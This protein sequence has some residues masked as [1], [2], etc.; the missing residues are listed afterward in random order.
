MSENLNLRGTNSPFTGIYQDINKGAVLTHTELD[1][2]F[3][4]LKGHIVYDA[5]VDVN[6]ITL[7]KLNGQDLTIDLVIPD[8]VTS[9]TGLTFNPSNYDLIMGKS[10][11]TSYTQS[12]SILATDM[13]VTGGT[14]NTNTGIVTF[15]NNSGGTFTVSGFLTGMT[16]T[17]WTSGST[18]NYSIK[19]K[20]NSGL[21]ATGNYALAEGYG[22]VGSGNYSHAEGSNSISSGTASHSEGGFTTASGNYSHAEGQG[23]K[24]SGLISHA[25]GGGTTSSGG[26][27][28]HSEGFLTK[29][30]GKSSHTEGYGT[31]ASGDYGSH[32][33]GKYTTASG[34]YGSHSEGFNTT[35]S[36][37]Y[38][39]A[40]GS[41]TLSSGSNSHAEGATT[42]ASGSA[43][44]AEGQG[45]TAS[46]EVSHVE[47]IYTIASG[48]GSHAEGSSTTA[49]GESSHA[50]GNG[51]IASGDASHAEGNQT[52]ASG[53]NS[54]ASGYYSIAS[55]ATSHAEGYQT[56]A[57][58]NYGSHAEGW[59]TKA[60]GWVSHAEGQ[61]TTASGYAA[62]SEGRET[63]ASGYY[64]HAEGMTNISSGIASHAEGRETTA[65][66]DASHTE[67]DGTT[68]IGNQSHAEGFYST[69]SGDYS[70]VEGYYSLA[71][72]DGSHAE[73]GW[74]DVGEILSGGTALGKASHAEGQETI[75]GWKG[76]TIDSVVDGLI[77]LNSSYGDVT[78]EFT[79][80]QVILNNKYYFYNTVTFSSTTNTQILLDDT[81]VNGGYMYV[82]DID[83]LNSQYADN[84]IGNSSHT[85]GRL[86][87]ALGDQAHAEGN[88]TT[89][90]GYAAH[91]EGSGTRAI[92]IISHAEGQG[93]TAIGSHSH[94]E[95]NY[96]IALGY[97][98]HVEGEYT[99]ASGSTSHAE[100]Q[101]TTAIGN[102]SHAEGYQTTAIGMVSHTEGR[103]TT[104]SGDYSHAEGYY[105]IASGEGS[106]AEGGWNDN[107]EILS[108]GTALGKA[109]HAEG[110]ET[111][112]G[113]KGFSVDSTVSGV[114]TLNSSYGDVTSEFTG[115][116]V[117]LDNEIYNFSTVTFS[118][119]TN[120]EIIL[121]DITVNGGTYV[122]DLD[123][124]NSQYADTLDVFGRSAHAEGNNTKSL[125]VDS[126]SEGWNTIATGAYGS[127]AEGGLTTASAWSSHAEGERTTASGT[128]SHAE[129]ELT[130]AIGSRSHSEGYLTVAQGNNSHAEGQ[131]TRS[132]SNASHAEGANTTA[133]GQN[134]HA[135][136]QYTNAIGTNSSASG[137]YTT[138]GWKGFSVD[139]VVNGLIM[140]T[141]SYGDVT[142]EFF[143]NTVILDNN[144]YTYNT[145]TFSSGT[146]T[147][148]ILN[149]TS[150]NFGYF[151]SDFQNINSQYANNNKG[152]S[153][154]TEGYI[155]T[156]LGNYSHAEGQSTIASGGASHAEGAGTTAIGAASHSEGM[157]TTA[158]GGQSHAE[159]R[160]TTA[161]GSY[162][163]SEGFITTAIGNYSHAEGEYT[164]AI[165]GHS[166][167]E[168]W[169]TI[170]SGD[171]SHAEGKETTASGNYSHAEGQWTAAIGS[172]SHAEGYLTTAS[173]VY[174]AHAE[175]NSSKAIGNWS[176]AE[177]GSTTASGT[178]SHA[179]GS[180]TIALGNYSHAEGS[181][182]TASGQVSHA[183]GLST[184][185]SGNQSHAEGTST[186]ASGYSSH[187][188]GY[189]T[190]A[191]GQRSHAEGWL[192]T[193][194]SLSSHAE[195]G[196]TLASGYASHAEGS[197]TTASGGSSHAEGSSTIAS[198]NNSHTEGTS[199]T[200]SGFASHAGGWNTI[201][202]GDTSFI[203][204]NNSA[205]LGNRS[206]VLGG[207][208]IT[209]STDD[210]V[211]VPYF[212][213]QSAT[214]DNELVEVLVIDTNGD[215]K[216]RDVSSIS[217]DIYWTSGSTGNYSIKAKN[218]SGLDATGNYAVA[219]GNSTMAS[220]DYGSHAEG[221]STMASGNYGSH[222]EGGSTTASGNYGSHAEGW[223]TTAS[224]SY[225]SHAEGEGTIA[226]GQRSHAEGWLTTASSLSSHAEG[227]GTIAS[228]QRS[229]AE[230]WL[231]TASSLSSH[232]E[233]QQTIASGENSHAEG[234]QTTAI[235]N[236]SHA[237][238]DRNVASG[239]QSHAEGQFTVASGVSSHAEGSNTISEGSYSHAEGDH[240]TAVGNWSH[241]EGNHTTTYGD[242][243]HAEGN[244][245]IATGE[246][247][248]AEG[249][250]TV[251][252]WKGFSIDSVVDGL[253]TLN[254]SYGNVTSE[255]I[256]NN[257][258]ILDDKIYG[259]DTIT[260]SSTTNTQILLDDITVNSG[261]YI[262]DID[263]LNSQYADNYLGNSTHAE[264]VGTKALG[265]NSHAE[266]IYSIALGSNSHAEGYGAFASGF[267]SHAEGAFTVASG[268]AAH[269][270][271]GGTIAS[272]D[273]SH[274]EGEGTTA[275]GNYSHAEGGY[276]T[277]SGNFSHA[278]GDHTTASGSYG[279]HA[280]GYQTTA[281]SL[282]SHSEGSATVA[283]G[284]YSHSEGQYTTAS[285]Y[286]SHAEGNASISNG[287]ASHS[288]GYYTTA[289]GNYSHSE[290]YYTTASG[291]YSH[292]EGQE[293][294]AGW[295]GFT[296]DS[297]V[298]GLITLNSSYGDVTGE[299]TGSAVILDTKIYYYTT[300]TF[301]STTNTQIL[302]SDITAIG[303]NYV[304]DL[305]NLNSQYA[306]NYVGNSAHAEG[307]G[308]Y[309]LGDRA[310]AEGFYT[311][312]TGVNSHTEGGSTIAIG[313]NSHA[314]GD[315]TKAIGYSSH[316]EGYY[317]LAQGDGSHA[318]GYLVI[319]SGLRAHA[320]GSGSIAIGD[321]SHAEGS[322]TTASGN[323]SHAEGSYTTA[324]GQGSH[325][326]GE[327]TVASEYYSHAE[328]L[329][330]IASGYASHAEGGT[331]TANGGYS[332]AE[333]YLTT[334]IGDFSHAEGGYNI[335]GG[336]SSH[337]GGNNS[338]ASGDTSFIHSKYSLVTGDRS[339]VLG[340]QFI[341]GSTDD[342]VYVP[343][344]NIQSATTNNNLTD[345]LVLDTN[346]DVKKRTINTIDTYATGFT[347]N[348]SN[349][350]LI[351]NQNNGQSDLSVNLGLLSSDMTVTGGTYNSTTGIATFTNNTGGTFTVLGFLTGMTDT[352][353]SGFTYGNNTL[354]IKQ[355]AGK[356]DLS[357]NIDTLTGLTINGN[358][359]ATTISNVDYIDF[360]KT[361]VVS[362]QEGR[363]HWN[364]S[365]KT[366][367]IDTENSQVQLK[368]GHDLV[369]R[370]NNQTASTILKGSAVYIN[371]EQGQR[372]TITLANYSGESTSAGTLGL[373]MGNISPSSNGY[374]I[375][376]GILEG[377]NTLAYSAGTPLYL[378][379]GGT[380]TSTKP[381]APNHDVRIG[382]VIV[383]NAT[384]G[385]IYV[386]IQNGYE[387]DELHD[388][389]ITSATTG[390][391]LV[392][393]TY[394]G[395][396]VW[397]N[398]KTLTGDYVVNGNLNVTGGTQSIFSG[399]SSSDLVR[400]TQTG[401]GNAFV[402]EDGNNPDATPFIIDAN[403]DVAI[404][405][406]IPGGT[407][408]KLTVQTSATS[409][410]IKLGGGN[411]L[412]NARLYLQSDATNAYMDMYGNDGYLPFRI[413]AAP[414]LLN[415]T[416]GTG[417]VGI[418]TFSPTA[419]LH[420]N[421]TYKLGIEGGVLFS[422]HGS[423][424]N[425][426]MTTLTG[427]GWTGSHRVS[428]SDSNGTVFFGAYGSST[429]LISSHWTVGSS[430]SIDGY[431][432]TTGI[433]LLKNGNVGIGTATPTQKLSVS[434][435]SVT[436]DNYYI[437]GAEYAQVPYRYVKQVSGLVSGTW[438]NICNV[439]GDS[440]SSGI[441][442]SI[443]GTA[444]ATVIDVVADIL[445]N[446]SQDIFI[447]SKSG[448]Y[449]I[450]T[451]RV[452]SDD[453]QNFTIQATTNSTSSLTANVE[454][455]PLNSESVI[456]DSITPYSGMLLQHDCVP[457]LSISSTDGISSNISNITTKGYLGVGINTPT[458]SLH[459]NNTG[460][461]NSFLVEDDS[462]PDN[463]P[464]IIDNQGRV[465]LGTNTPTAKLHV[466]KGLQSDTISVENSAA[467]IAGLDVGLAI[468]QSASAPYGNW[469]QSLRPSD[470][471]TF[472][473]LLNPSGSNVGIGITIPT[474]SLHV[475][476]TAVPSAGETIAQFDVSDDSSYLRI[477][478]STGAN[479]TFIPA[480]ESY[481]SSNK[482]A[483][484]T[485]GNGATDTGA[486]PLL[487]FDARIGAA[488]VATRPL[489]QWS[490]YGDVKMTMSASGNIG[491][492]TAS[493]SAKLHVSGDTRITGTLT[494]TTISAT[495]Y[496]N[497]PLDIYTTGGTYNSGT[498]IATFTNNS[499]GTFIVSGFTTGSTYQTLEEVLVN[500]N[501]TGQNWI[502]VD[503][504][505]SGANGIRNNDP[506]DK[507]KKIEFSS[508]GILTEV[509]GNITDN[510][511][512]ISIVQNNITL[513]S[514]SDT[515]VFPTNEAFIELHQNGNVVINNSNSLDITSEYITIAGQSGTFTGVEYDQD[516]STNFTN[517][518][519]VDKEYVDNLV[520]GGG[521]FTGGTV[522]G[523]TNFTGGLSAN[524]I[525]ATTYQNLPKVGFS[526][527][528][529]GVCDTAPTA[530]STQYYY[531]TIGEVT[532][533]LS[534]VKLWGFSGSDLVL[535]GIY[536]GTL[537]GTMTLIGQASGTC[538]TGPNELTLTAETGQNLTITAGEDLVV[539]YYPDGTNWRTVYDLGISD[540][541]FG[542][543]NTT[544]ITTMPASPTGTATAIRFACTLY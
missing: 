179:E 346:G 34:D 349:Y 412:G 292:S 471:A 310:H 377:V 418:G 424:T 458:A 226:S 482:T 36:G 83:N 147:E 105:T 416:V 491:I 481:N 60:S 161:S 359:T 441:K 516:Y 255:F 337:A 514:K 354:T 398:S 202:S 448:V 109:S 91:S 479:N 263:K 160:N 342:T 183:E 21:N 72:G 318:E 61:W 432:L 38:S 384:T 340:G 284:N 264:G 267:A 64:S 464:F 39:H 262:A 360:N 17:Y 205:V 104:A 469:I 505:G 341:T 182:T 290:G 82:A 336:A 447:E 438:T 400:I 440:L 203:H 135:E 30:I 174:G 490:N 167:A 162:S 343:Y 107:G 16:D 332:H 121:I 253:I 69:A 296:V 403:G 110:Q 331:T 362:H 363:I 20:N 304:A 124:L 504:S 88:S 520:V 97:S 189:G 421:G 525:S 305:N 164:T 131:G 372:P 357:V 308:T 422:S 396:N 404:G 533:T 333:G 47:G 443:M 22:T 361:A 7:K 275:S 150:I 169:D 373:A 187:A 24:A 215:V 74:N 329:G 306:D 397:V 366:L 143:S 486:E 512:S 335:A 300:V 355:T 242:K 116:K 55:G 285:G 250:E 117:I 45:S 417:N 375:T 429:S 364:D 309:A 489:F 103:G 257:T 466:V 488:Q 76:F 431:D 185:A 122:A 177:G 494:A 132:L 201:A 236:N 108:G 313:Q 237:E 402:V 228:G 266:G 148:I 529:V 358:L 89:A 442:L 497:L 483:L 175:G 381:Q 134:S 194:S 10:D 450:L 423:G 453:N 325:A 515:G 28:S 524:T 420:V 112:A 254:S 291:T 66:G 350:D 465:G 435:G 2:N 184:I 265:D 380:L 163:H 348:P 111:I 452:I 139:S 278:E 390:D 454:V 268:Y 78:G 258:I 280:E 193:A 87:K 42:T 178:A 302:L 94:A 142:S 330:T 367:E 356:P 73:G 410:T 170:A 11:G 166:H 294:I 25:E 188:E 383:S 37:N 27:G 536:R 79:G 29:A 506:L 470:N 56:T 277:A 171:T 503:I 528:N 513:L 41:L 474:A 120:T 136:G 206:A 4:T 297:V 543:S 84:Y 119:T 279:S 401:L 339:V 181:N 1:Q 509:Y 273:K 70:H 500:G 123:N 223:L 8:G 320:E 328:G 322:Y 260:F 99:T 62:H 427:G 63:T 90:S 499:G 540:I 225:G 478:N 477:S 40:E 222:A 311:Y 425:L 484:Y 218:D 428:T 141:S 3:I 140:L 75:A 65:S 392:R 301:S 159:G 523:A 389:R 519:L 156:A 287:K 321:S 368:V 475:R 18:G 241:V 71:H 378:Y 463:T 19:A 407:G 521:S 527:I 522:S 295:K 118:S 213:I 211:Y 154:H 197:E 233:G 44:H 158:S 326:E 456:F 338:I 344:F 51:T 293:T 6:T 405:N 195:G 157:F 149:N 227:E 138:A 413:D 240:S 5:T 256:T 199:T 352:Y 26:Y 393:S 244:W 252:G 243:S 235:G 209:G 271:G 508:D 347:F 386:N 319:A 270:E 385:S 382:K 538:T 219:E 316:A 299:F 433:H 113:W 391:L 444:G 125:G 192:T 204:S 93:T 231:T 434:G 274:V 9:I 324:S 539:G 186:T 518:S 371:G 246:N 180:Q 485:L 511:S 172:R 312:A 102:L 144:L 323:T 216:K 430:S 248:H 208:N 210:T 542:I 251:A 272:G 535:F 49:Q 269:A 115:N 35:A 85:E 80:G 388:V 369:V 114:I 31:T 152:D 101:G 198:G 374:V 408:A 106:H 459:V 531:Q 224:G 95:G 200:A 419:K 196:V 130:T 439:L 379:T 532:T 303:Y 173:G 221:N 98:S 436:A 493:P 282:S 468:G 394:N 472:P 57:S 13:T 437:N 461:G 92:G 317:S 239:N 288:E 214:T 53:N 496:Q 534:K 191:S 165:G 32:A 455:F 77:T 411:G 307:I 298:D 526:P 501:S 399:N 480:L 530:A 261:T 220:G 492:G 476:T 137:Y 238:G 457:G 133:V 498:G 370:V 59:L 43:S 155:T 247:S 353:V 15:T 245:T 67:G 289:S 502:E 100:G 351:I 345:I 409:G 176:H 168:G 207:Q 327:N 52:T 54:S 314:E 58:G 460:V 487:T 230:G 376:Q 46:G 212:N 462:N 449:T 365:I 387:L 283:S 232:A 315:L 451:L 127:H 81:T 541:L 145:V 50:E 517:R 446:H 281:S 14:F 415:S 426:D 48:A 445:V 229:H 473:L 129:G 334:A 151:V 537:G 234:S 259:I 507:D 414:L 406:P 510:L 495:T 286:A 217:D 146:N 33:E 68:A 249:L 12:L 86:T 126:H 23:S 190:I 153:T 395:S 276:T 544:N 467:W 128:R 96:T